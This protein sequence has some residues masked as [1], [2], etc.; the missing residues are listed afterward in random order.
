MTGGLLCL[1]AE[2]WRQE[3]TYRHVYTL[4]WGHQEPQEVN[5]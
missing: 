5:E 2:L 4:L 1:V 3:E